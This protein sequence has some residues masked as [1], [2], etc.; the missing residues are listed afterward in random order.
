MPALNTSCVS[1]PFFLALPFQTASR[2]L[3]SE[4]ILLSLTATFY[5]CL[6]NV[7]VCVCV[8]QTATLKSVYVFRWYKGAHGKIK[9]RNALCT[10]MYIHCKLAKQSRTAYVCVCVC[11]CVSVCVCGCRIKISNKH[12]GFVNT[13]IEERLLVCVLIIFGRVAYVP[14]AEPSLIIIPISRGGESHINL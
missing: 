9:W 8:Q 5:F 2:L 14:R 13:P 10:F 4:H 11:V 6:K 3:L 12:F 7:S 1:P